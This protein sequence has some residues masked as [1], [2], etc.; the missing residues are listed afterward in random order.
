MKATRKVR[1]EWLV[2][3]EADVNLNQELARYFECTAGFETEIIEL[4]CQDGKTRR[5]WRLAN[6]KMADNL[7]NNR[8]DLGVK[9]LRIYVVRIYGGGSRSEPKDMTDIL[10][11][12]KF[13]QKKSRKKPKPR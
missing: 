9:N 10:F 12:H 3:A 4:K 2:L 5:F 7:W 11:N 6:K 8:V 1:F 13:V